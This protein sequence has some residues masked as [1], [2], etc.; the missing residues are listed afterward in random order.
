MKNK[1]ILVEKED[2]SKIITR[3]SHEIIESCG[4]LS[5]VVVIGIKTRGEF[6]AQR[7]IKEIKR[8]KSLL[9]PIG[10][11]DITFHRDDFSN[12]FLTPKLGPSIIPCDLN[13]KQII[14]VDDVL[15]TGRTIRSAIDEI[16]SFGRPKNIRLAVLVDRGHRELPIRPD[17]IG[18][19]LPT[20]IDE[21]IMV[22][23]VE[24]DKLDSI[25]KVSK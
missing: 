13:D 21:H 2:V 1:N 19:N 4:D 23:M 7:I 12:K 18:K 16:F 10:T 6:V 14:L 15:Y 8:I 20:S 25:I 17:F 9:L 3:I 22:N 11:L 24:T 5:D